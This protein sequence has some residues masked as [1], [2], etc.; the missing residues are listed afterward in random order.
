[1]SV[2]EEIGFCFLVTNQCTAARPFRGNILEITKCVQEHYLILGRKEMPRYAMD[3]EM[4]AHGI[5]VIWSRSCSELAIALK[6]EL[7]YSS[8]S[9]SD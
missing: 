2:N 4:E 6:L 8:H 3:M 1:M 9:N 7:L 5:E